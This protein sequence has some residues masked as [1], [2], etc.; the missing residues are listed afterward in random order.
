VATIENLTHGYNDR[1]LFKDVNLEIERGDRVAIIGPNGAGGREWV[2]VGG[3]RAVQTA[4]RP[5]CQ[6]DDS[7]IAHLRAG[8]MASLWS[9]TGY[10][11]CCRATL[12]MCV[13]VNMTVD[14]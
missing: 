14:P 3:D 2:W 9:M 7:W 10:L 13:E 5:T 1:L 11:E 4:Q 12:H 6:P 8:Y